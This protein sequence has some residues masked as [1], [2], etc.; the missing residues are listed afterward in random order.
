M[1]HP[2]L[3]RYWRA[4]DASPDPKMF[5]HAMIGALS[6]LVDDDVWARALDTATEIDRTSTSAAVR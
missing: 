1:T 3:A 2:A 5:A 4:Q 6:L